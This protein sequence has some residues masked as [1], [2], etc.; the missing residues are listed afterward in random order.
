[1]LSFYAYN[2]L[3]YST[4][5][6]TILSPQHPPISILSTQL[7]ADFHSRPVPKDRQGNKKPGA[8]TDVQTVG[9]PGNPLFSTLFRYS[10][11][12]LLTSILRTQHAP[13]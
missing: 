11:I 4:P 2:H 3:I 7:S 12:S 1:M 8:E 10:I 6:L 13:S 9:A 5:F